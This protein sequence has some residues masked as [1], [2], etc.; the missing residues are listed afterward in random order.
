[1]SQATHNE[2]NVIT[3]TN[4]WSYIQMYDKELLSANTQ[5]NLPV[6]TQQGFK[7]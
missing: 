1:M 4:I 3:L 2:Q 6:L 7:D 5:D